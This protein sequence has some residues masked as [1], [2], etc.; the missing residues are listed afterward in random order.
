MSNLVSGPLNRKFT[1]TL[2]WTMNARVGP[3]LFARWL[4]LLFAFNKPTIQTGQRNPNGN[5]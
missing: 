3:E 5:P 1:S 2:E 4:G